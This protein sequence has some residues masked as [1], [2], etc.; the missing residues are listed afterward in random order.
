MTVIDAKDTQV[1]AQ[2]RRGWPSCR[3]VPTTPC[4]VR[5]GEVS[6]TVHEGIRAGKSW[7]A[8]RTSQPSISHCQWSTCSSAPGTSFQI[9][10]MNVETPVSI[11]GVFFAPMRTFFD[12]SGYCPSVGMVAGT[13]SAIHVMESLYTWS[14]CRVIRCMC[15][16]QFHFWYAYVDG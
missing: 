10:L 13:I 3:P 2:E 6:V 8:L 4:R 12:V 7:C 16:V 5:R 15:R 9:P 14:L 1:K 11:L